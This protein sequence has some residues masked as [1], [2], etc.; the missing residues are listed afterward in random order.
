[1]ALDSMLPTGKPLGTSSTAATKW[2]LPAIRA[3]AGE[4]LDIELPAAVA[5]G[6]VPA[7]LDPLVGPGRRGHGQAPGDAACPR[8]AHGE[9]VD[10][11]L[12][13]AVGRPCE[14]GASPRQAPA[15]VA[16]VDV[17]VL[18]TARFNARSVP[19]E[20]RLPCAW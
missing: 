6:D 4:T 5:P 18:V 12:P 16:P 3:L 13:A 2:P 20:S 8:Q 15:A 14:K 19:R 17:H 10:L 7:M 11:E 1:M 9:T